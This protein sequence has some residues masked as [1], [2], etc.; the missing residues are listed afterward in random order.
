MHYFVQR[1]DLRDLY[2]KT[3]AGERLSDADALRLFESRDLNAVG[4][5]A[6]LARQR[7]VGNRASYI[8][9]RYI[10]YSNYCILSC[11]FCSFARK[12]RDADGFQLSL[13]EIVD[14]ARE[15]LKLGI[16]ELH[17][18]GGL[19]PS[20]PFTYYLEM[21]RALRSLDGRLQLKC[22][23]AIEVLHLSWLARKSVDETLRELKAAG[24]DSL[25]GGGAEIFRKE[26][27]SAIALG[28]ES[29]EEY[30]DVHRQ[31]HQLGGRSTCT[32]LYGHVETLADRVDH[33]RRLRELQDETR[34]FVGF[35]PLPYQP[36]NNRIPVSHP[37]TGYDALRT[38]AV[39]RIY[40]DNFDHITAY[41]VGLGLKLAQV[42]LSYGADDLH[43]TILEEHIFHMAGA[44]TPQLQTEAAMVKAIREAGR[45]PVQRDTFYQP[46]KVW[47]DSVPEAG[48]SDG[49]TPPYEH[50]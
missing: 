44:A 37:P 7:R 14:K 34:G 41:W 17:I 31:W 13:E 27:R 23:T 33:L 1:S 49:P 47:E 40:L 48:T 18:V 20:L 16:T 39:S 5:I 46:V 11:Q 8:L 50:A 9:N 19:H 38:I 28:K 6:D 15:A 2:E 29:A 36:E 21:L 42:A 45:I 35:V 26:V 4:A 22:F 3:A 30:L 10:N 24:L 43:G 12:K 32:M 25:T